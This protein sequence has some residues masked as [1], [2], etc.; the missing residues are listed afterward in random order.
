VAE[1]LA[2]A[3]LVDLGR[4]PIL[5][6]GSPAGA[7]LL[8]RARAQIAATGA[9]ELDGFVTG[10][11]LAALIEDAFALE[12]RAHHSQGLG[13]AYLGLPDLDRPD[14]HPARWYGEYAVGAVA[15]DQTPP[16]SPLR[17]LYEWEPLMR[18]VEAV[19]ER[20]TLHPYADPM[21]ALNLAV[22][23]AGEQLQWHFDQTDFV[24]SLAIRDADQGGDFE[25]IPHIR[26][27]SDERYAD[28][29]AVLDG[30]RSRVVRLPMT[31][32]TL[33]IFEG[34]NSIHRVSPIVGPTT[35]LVGLL[36]Y[37]TKP[38]TVSSD[39]LRMSRYGRI[40]PLH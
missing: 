34:R 21:G 29:A 9:V 27:A 28:V 17:Q 15:Y 23:G 39:L 5:D 13:T 33:L 11:G 32:G 4:Y 6:L 30:D 8:A 36:A 38:D 7:A 2:P 20:G 3:E 10:G 19:L 31:P 35:R 16:R 24:V 26:S 12:P 22:M 25:V 40:E 37:D 14:G 18:F 1:V